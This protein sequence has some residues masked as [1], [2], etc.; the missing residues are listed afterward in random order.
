[1]FRWGKCGVYLCRNGCFFK[2]LGGKV[3]YSCSVFPFFRWI[4][5]AWRDEL[6][7]M[8]YHVFFL[9]YVSF[10]MI[11]LIYIFVWVSIPCFSLLQFDLCFFLEKTRFISHF[12]SGANEKVR[13]VENV[14]KDHESDWCKSLMNCTIFLQKK[15]VA[16][17]GILYM[18]SIFSSIPIYCWHFRHL[19]RWKPLMEVHGNPMKKMVGS[20]PS[21]LVMRYAP[22]SSP[23][24]MWRRLLECPR[25]GGRLP[26]PSD[27]G[28]AA[29]F[30]T[31]C[32][33]ESGG[34]AGA[35]GT[36][37]HWS[38]TLCGGSG[39]GGQQ[40]RCGIPPGWGLES[41]KHEDL[42]VFEDY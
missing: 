8:R 4:S 10:I 30:T 2:G 29:T 37:R 11:F 31:Q 3:L 33:G 20:S 41:Q 22:I 35:T 17:Q 5:P 40:I 26:Y 15:S 19:L 32:G 14:R 1:M 6:V 42:N 36:W 23:A 28:Y 39:S 16:A 34:A 25:P 7:T 27:P 24:A 18:H 9:N 38:T 12:R 13:W 21:Q